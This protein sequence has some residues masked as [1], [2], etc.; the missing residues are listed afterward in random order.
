MEGFEIDFMNKYLKTAIS[1]SILSIGTAL[2]VLIWGVS[3]NE[4]GF[5][6]FLAGLGIYTFLAAVSRSFDKDK[7][8]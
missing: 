3:I 4:I 1:V 6:K 2:L 7:D 5:L 8:L